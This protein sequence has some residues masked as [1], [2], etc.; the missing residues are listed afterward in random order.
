MT[1][2]LAGWLLLAIAAFGS[3]LPAAADTPRYTPEQVR[4]DIDATAAGIAAT[5]PQ[6]SFSVDPHHLDQVLTKMRAEADHDVDRDDAWR[7]LSRLNP[8]LADGHFFVGYSSWRDEATRHLKSGGQLFPFEVTVGADKT[9]RIVAKLGGAATPLAGS[10]ITTINGLRAN[11]VVD[12]LLRHVHGDTDNFRAGLLSERWWFFYWKI[13]GAP[14]AFRIGLASK[15]LPVVESS[16]GTAVPAVLANETVFDRQFHLDIRPDGVAVMTVNTF[17]WPE[18]DA[19]TAFTRTAFEQMQA[20]GT[21]VLIV[22]V[23]HNGGGD[24]AMW[25]EGLLPYIADKPYRW[26]SRYIKKVNKPDPAKGEHVGDV[27]E[28]A[29]DSWTTP[30]PAQPYRFRG[31]TY[32]LVGR[33]TYSSAVLFAN[34]MQDFGFGV[35]AGEGRSVRAKQS[36]G[37][38]RIDLPNTGL[39][40]WLPRFVLTR[41]SGRDTSTWLTPDLPLGDDPLN[42]SA[43]VDAAVRAARGDSYAPAASPRRS[44]LQASR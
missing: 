17:A 22:D 42:Q 29:I 21:R 44:K 14:R 10:R 37:V 41:P 36:G 8:V 25:L 5:H 15:Q 1:H 23:R 11:V 12:E 26:A 3:P 31:K 43:M 34:T 18:P 9:A 33:T 2:R 35:V 13:Y 6:P 16:G 7:A 32:V 39:A 19:F 38:Q 20:A 28:G 40:L 24:D 27:L 4:Q 30:D